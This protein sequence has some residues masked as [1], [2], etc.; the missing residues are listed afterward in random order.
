MDVIALLFD[1]IFR[2]PSIPDGLRDL[3]GRLQVPIVKAALL[4][5]HVLLGQ[6]HPARLLLDHLADAA[7]GATNDEG[8]REAFERGRAASSTT[9]AAIS[10]STS[11]CSRRRRRAGGVHRVRAAQ[12]GGRGEGGRQ[13]GAGRRG[14][15]GGPRRRACADARQAGRTRSA[16]RSPRFV[17]TSWSDYL[18]QLRQRTAAAAS[19]GMRRCPRSTNCCG[20]SSPRSALRKRRGSPS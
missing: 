9:S 19:N 1:Y 7:V 15:R 17:E 18:A 3:F 13:R 12:D 16:L 11:P 6:T 20:A 14:K 8:Y 4:R 10:R 5:P 2:D